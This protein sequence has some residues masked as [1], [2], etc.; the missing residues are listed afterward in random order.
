MAWVLGVVFGNFKKYNELTAL[1]NG[2]FQPD[3][4]TPKGQ[5]ILG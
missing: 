5:S 3:R 2:F 4:P 1:E